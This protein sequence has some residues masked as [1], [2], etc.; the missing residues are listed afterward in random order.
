MDPAARPPL[1]VA[2]LAVL[3]LEVGLLLG[4]AGF[5]LVSVVRG[6]SAE[7]GMALASGALAALIGGFLGL[8][9]WALWRGRRWARAPVITWQLLQLAVAAP[10]V[11][12]PAWWAGLALVAASLLVGGG[13]L[14][15]AVVRATAST[16]DP[17]VT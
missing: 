15:P 8:C 1:L 11:T 10:A 14:A 5:S 3:A 6:V 12:G 4:V 16:A 2:V 13:L 9:G 7:P 17:P